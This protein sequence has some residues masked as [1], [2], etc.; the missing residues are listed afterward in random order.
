VSKEPVDPRVRAES[1]LLGGIS[2]RADHLLTTAGERTSDESTDSRLPEDHLRVTPMGFRFDIQGLRAVAVGM[3]VLYHAGL[4]I[5]GG[6]T[7]VDIFFVL[8][9]FVIAQMMLRQHQSGEGIS[10]LSFFGK[11]FKRLTPALAVMVSTVLLLSIVLLSPF[12]GQQAVAQTALGAMLL[13]AN[14]VIAVTSGGYFDAPAESNALLNTWSLS[15]EEQFYLAF[16]LLLILGWHLDKHRTKVKSSAVVILAAL[17]FISFALAMAVPQLTNSTELPGFLGF[18]SPIARVWEFA[19][20]ALLALAAPHLRMRSRRYALAFGITGFG[21][22]SVSALLINEDTRFPGPATIIPVAGTLLLLASGTNKSVLT[23]RLLSLRPVTLIG[24]YS[25]SIYLWHWPAIVVAATVL[26][27]SRWVLVSAVLISMIPAVASYRWVEQPI[28]RAEWK[29]A[30]QW[31]RAIVLTFSAPLVLALLV[32]LG[33]QAKWWINWES[34]PSRTEQIARSTCVDSAFGPVLCR[35]SA[36]ETRGEILLVGDSQAYAFADGVVEAAN[37]LGYDVVVSSRSGCPL[38]TVDTSGS[39]PLD[40]ASWQRTVLDYAEGTRPAAVILA[41]R[42][43]GYVNPQLNWRTFLSEEG[44]PSDYESASLRY[45][46]G[47]R[48]VAERL[49]NQQVPILVLQNIPEPSILRQ[50]DSIIRRLILDPLPENFDASTTLS[51]RERASLI[52]I[53]VAA[54]FAGVQ[55]F[56]P[57][58]TLCRG[59]TCDLVR[60]ESLLYLDT[61][62]LSRTGSLSLVESLTGALLALGIEPKIP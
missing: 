45:E 35:W 14:L 46:Q 8:S 61:F 24:D 9:G 54:E 27:R 5:P 12:G 41:N 48:E 1:P 17:F 57:A 32:L 59:T 40:C 33:A 38:L 47:L 28:R 21:L 60:G 29:G 34:Q 18:Y 11:R 52:E 42:S 25:Y 26:G 30:R 62:H 2:H 6:F 43:L 55:L 51:L 10:L 4:P 13:A 50:R 44:V 58:E 7:G 36:A 39:K 3:V 56:D 31:R 15:V 19:A 22:L 49:R 37:S 23:T 53:D 16:P 20:G